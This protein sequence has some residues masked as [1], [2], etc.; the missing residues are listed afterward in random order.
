[1]SGSLD[2]KALLNASI[3]NLLA[4]G[5]Y[6]DFEIVC[7][8]KSF[9]VHK[10][11]ICP[12]SEYFKRAVTFGKEAEENKI[13]LQEDEAEIIGYMLQYLY[14]GDYTLPSAS[15]TDTVPPEQ[16]TGSGGVS[17]L[18]QQTGSFY[19]DFGP[20]QY[21]GPIGAS[22]LGQQTGIFNGEI[23]EPAQQTG[24]IGG[25]SRLGQH[26]GSLLSASGPIRP[27]PRGYQVIPLP[28]LPGPG[29]HNRNAGTTAFPHTCYVRNFDHP[30][31][32]E[33]L[34]RHHTCGRDCNSRDK[35]HTCSICVRP[36]T[37]YPN[38][39]PGDLLDHAK[40]YILADKYVIKGLKDLVAPRF[41]M[42]CMASWNKPEFIE[43]ADLVYEST[44][45]TDHKLRNIIV[46]TFAEHME[47]LDKADDLMNAHNGLAFAV[48]KKSNPYRRR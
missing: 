32:N 48:L 28:R 40:L 4:S 45:D 34:C 39:R 14:E 30:A 13:D 46:D 5:Q 19:G 6:S 1:M 16:S 38:T 9:K 25:G 35:Y 18:G 26:T 17:G 47:L 12:R 20:A 3:K 8:G 7:Q 43:A 22:R 44:P 42:A 33:T 23:F 15:S 10:A 27:I 31:C 21:P 41:K 29:T 36:S 2:G 37:A 24:P 11:I